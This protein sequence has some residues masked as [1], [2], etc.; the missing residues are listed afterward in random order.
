MEPVEVVVG[1]YESEKDVF[2]GFKACF[3]GEKIADFEAGDRRRFTLYKCGWNR[4]EGYRVYDSDETNPRSPTYELM[5]HE[6][7]VNPDDPHRAYHKLYS[8][9]EVAAQWPVFAKDIDALQAK[10][11]D[12]KTSDPA[13][14]ER[15]TL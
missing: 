9:S 6:E 7:E 15:R 11:I 13:W 1:Q 5:P 10:D 4:L 12:A 8:P 2:R 3:M 14:N